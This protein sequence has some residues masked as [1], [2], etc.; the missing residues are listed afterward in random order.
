[1]SGGEWRFSSRLSPTVCPMFHNFNRGLHNLRQ[2]A[3]R[4]I[5]RQL[6]ES[7]GVV[8]TSCRI[9]ALCDSERSSSPNCKSKKNVSNNVVL[10][11]NF[12]IT[13][14]S[15]HKHEDFQK[16]RLK[17]TGLG[18]TKCV[19]NNYCTG[20]CNSVWNIETCNQW[21]TTQVRF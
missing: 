14:F 12:G 1:M 9:D 3:P 10:S 2:M 20:I 17:S 13:N 8:T 4:E 18:S 6:Q 16:N 5:Y 11:V 7:E 21:T 19:T 15:F